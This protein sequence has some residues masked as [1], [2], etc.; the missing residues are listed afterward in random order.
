MGYVLHLYLL[1]A[2]L[3]ILC[4]QLDTSHV[5]GG[6]HLHEQVFV[7]GRVDGVAYKHILARRA[8]GLGEVA[9]A[10]VDDLLHFESGEVAGYLFGLLERV[11]VAL[12]VD[13]SPA[14][15]A[16]AVDAVATQL[17]LDALALGVHL[18]EALLVLLSSYLVV[19]GV[20]NGQTLD[21]EGVE[22][23]ARLD[24]RL[25]HGLVGQPHGLHGVAR[26]V[27]DAGQLKVAGGSPFAG[28]VVVQIA[29]GLSQ[30]LPGLVVVGHQGADGSYDVRSGIDA[31]GVVVLGG[32]FLHLLGSLQ[33]LVALHAVGVE[34]GLVGPGAVEETL[35]ARLQGLDF[36]PFGE[37][38]EVGLLGFARAEHVVHLFGQLFDVVSLGLCLGY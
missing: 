13:E 28:E 37:R 12:L 5:H 3:K 36:E 21:A 2:Q 26:G 25:V 14:L 30:V 31:V 23:V 16:R 19:A 17:L 24:A 8:V 35:V 29:D 1:V 15:H 33:T 4:L 7:A 22:L 11:V 32:V 38:H 18:V 9:L 34:G 6:G 10:L 27:F 20:G